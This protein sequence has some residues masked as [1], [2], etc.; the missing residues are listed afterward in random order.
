MKGDTVFDPFLDLYILFAALSF[1]LL[2]LYILFALLSLSSEVLSLVPEAPD[3]R[4]VD[5][6]D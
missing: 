6:G 2:A 3:V 4:S 5:I 1:A